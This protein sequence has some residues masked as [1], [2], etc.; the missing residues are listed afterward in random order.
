MLEIV[1]YMA[2]FSL[3]TTYTGSAFAILTTVIKTGEKSM[4]I[5]NIGNSILDDMN[6][7]RFDGDEIVF[8]PDSSEFI[9]ENKKI[10]VVSMNSSQ[11]KTRV[12]FS[13]EKHNFMLEYIIYEK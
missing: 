9:L 12:E 4:R 6:K 13:I 1:I 10:S 8:P 3:I 11:T 5:E 7:Q 2:I